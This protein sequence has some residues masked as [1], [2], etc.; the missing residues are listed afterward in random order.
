[1]QGKK[2]KSYFKLYKMYFLNVLNFYFEKAS[3]IKIKKYF[4]GLLLEHKSI[5]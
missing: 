4:F 3:N 2:T 1:M 5:F